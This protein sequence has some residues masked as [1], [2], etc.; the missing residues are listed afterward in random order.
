MTRSKY[1]KQ[2]G[3]F[4]VLEAKQLFAADLLGGAAADSAD[5][6]VVV[7]RPVNTEE[8]F[9]D[10]VVAE[11]VDGTLVQFRCASCFGLT[12][13]ELLEQTQTL[14]GL[15]EDSAFEN[16][17]EKSF[18]AEIANDVWIQQQ[19]AQWNQWMDINRAI[20]D[21]ISSLAQNYYDYNM[22]I[23][24]E[25]EAASDAQIEQAMQRMEDMARNGGGSED[26]GYGSY[27]G[28]GSDDHGNYSYWV[29]G[30]DHREDGGHDLAYEIRDYDTSA[31]SDRSG[32]T[33]VITYDTNYADREERQTGDSDEDD[34]GTNDDDEKSWW[35]RRRERREARREERNSSDESITAESESGALPFMLPITEFYA[36]ETINQLFEVLATDIITVGT[37]T[38]YAKPNQLGGQEALEA[39]A[40]DLACQDRLFSTNLNAFLAAEDPNGN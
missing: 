22:N 29:E 4:E 15:T 6:A 8:L 38:E 35:E 31:G 25:Q 1:S 19:F 11:A 21:S 10:G 18:L 13:D 7:Y 24:L 30:R 39:L 26:Y 2:R 27:S 5:T 12:A 40:V 33:W 16:Y 14:A 23:M 36:N 34:N 17:D 28:R 32:E 37:F 20:G 3:Q 9:D